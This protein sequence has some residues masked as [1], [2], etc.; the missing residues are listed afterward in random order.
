LWVFSQSRKSIDKINSCD[1]TYISNNLRECE[2]KF[3]K[4]IEDS[5]KINYQEGLANSYKKLSIVHALLG[6]YKAAI[7]DNLI[8]LKIF[9]KNKNYKEIAIANA[10]I[11]YRLRYLDYNQALSYFRKAINIAEK[12]KLEAELTSIY[13]NYGETIKEKYIDSALIYFEKSLFLAKK[14]KISISIPFSLNKIAETYAKKKEFKK[15]FAYLNESDKLRFKTK[16]SVGIADNLAYRADIY[17]EIPLIDSA[18]FYY[19]KSL[20][21]S[22]STNYNS[23]ERFCLNRLADLYQRKNNFK[24]AYDVFKKFKT[25]EDSVLNVDVKNNIANLEIKYDS[26]KTKRKLAENEIKLENRRKWLL[27]AFGLT[28]LSLVFVFFVYRYQKSKRENEKK[29]AE[30]SKALKAAEIEK[31]F[32]EEKLRIGRE[33][34]DNIGSHLTFM[35]SSLDNLA[36]VKNAQSSL[37]KISDLSNFGRLTMKD[38]RDTIWAM[39]H[40]DGTFEHLITR[41]SELRA[42]LPSTLEVKIKSEIDNQ[43]TLSGIQLL[44]CYRIVQ[45]FIQNTIKYANATEIQVIIKNKQREFEISLCDNGSG[46]D[47]SSI[48]FGNGILNMKRRCEDLNGVFEI[49]SNEKGTR[50]ICLVPFIN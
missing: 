48:N 13:N 36:Y 39:N 25:L 30:L 5:K 37:D 43:Q 23:L 4:N 32:V 21:I 45:E 24:K 29:E 44:N 42:A 22:E 6:D 18:I 2:Q 17:Y 50:I 3:R 33:L 20:K 35:I 7:E 26:E 38:L 14:H 47:L 19:E 12:N 46:F 9:E 15:A 31:Q 49:E 27:I 41:I 8:A 16:D 40:E 34:H 28:I 1:Y 11:A 10:D